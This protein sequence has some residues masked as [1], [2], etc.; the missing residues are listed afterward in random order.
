[1]LI[2]GRI[3]LVTNKNSYLICLVTPYGPTPILE[4]DSKEKLKLF[5]ESIIQFCNI[6]DC[7]VP[8]AFVRAFSKSVK[9]GN[10]GDTATSPS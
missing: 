7:P 4:F 1:M 6:Y 9:E 10:S 5:G 3:V 8:E 2:P